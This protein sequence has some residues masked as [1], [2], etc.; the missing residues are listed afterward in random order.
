MQI[1]TTVRNH[2]TSTKTA[3]IKKTVCAGENV[4]KLGPSYVARTDVKWYSLCGK[5]FCGSSEGFN[6]HQMTSNSTLRYIAK[7]NENISTILSTFASWLFFMVTGWLTHS[8]TS[9][10]NLR[11]EESKNK[12]KK[13]Q[14]WLLFRSAMRF[15]GGGFP[16]N[17]V[18]SLECLSFGH[19]WMKVTIGK[20]SE[21]MIRPTTL[22]IVCPDN[23]IITCFI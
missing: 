13:F 11:T 23:L 18:C 22:L 19:P 17:F 9:L 20:V 3:T 2:F 15:L 10:P 14:T 16:R 8:L 5:Q 12:W 1:K 4:E 21:D 6:N 7:R